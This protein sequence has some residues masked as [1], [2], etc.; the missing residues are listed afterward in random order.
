MASGEGETSDRP[1][2]GNALRIGFARKHLIKVSI[3]V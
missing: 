2:H 3:R 1:A